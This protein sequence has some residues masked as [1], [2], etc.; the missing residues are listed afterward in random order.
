MIILRNKLSSEILSTRGTAGFDKNR[1]YDENLG[2]LGMMD[3]SQRELSKIGDLS[4]EN[5]KLS[6]EISSGLKQSEIRKEMN[7]ES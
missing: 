7:K 5:R 1:K 4:K 6:K 2:R 3:T